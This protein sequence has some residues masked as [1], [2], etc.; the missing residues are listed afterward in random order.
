MN[1]AR[2]PLGLTNKRSAGWSDSLPPAQCRAVRHSDTLGEK[3]SRGI[4]EL[5]SPG[6]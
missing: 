3:S 5:P 1:V 4:Q 6:E 2:E